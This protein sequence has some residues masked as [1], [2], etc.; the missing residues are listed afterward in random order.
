M[1][2]V[3]ESQA[4]EQRTTLCRE[5]SLL[6]MVRVASESRAVLLTTKLAERCPARE[7][8]LLTMDLDLVSL[9]HSRL[10]PEFL[11]VAEPETRSSAMRFPRMV[12][13]ESICLQFLLPPMTIATATRPQTI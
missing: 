1:N 13:L 9:E 4:S 2:S 3:S 12:A 6:A 5:I 10:G 8:P 11:S 7:T